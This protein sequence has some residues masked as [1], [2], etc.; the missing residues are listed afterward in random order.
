M[1]ASQQN[2]ASVAVWGIAVVAAGIVSFLIELFFIPLAIR[3]LIAYP[4]A[5]TVKNY[6]SLAISTIYLFIVLGGVIA[7][8][9]MSRN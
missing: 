6:S 2:F 9:A 3:E 1:A 4:S 8:I 7:F 5:R